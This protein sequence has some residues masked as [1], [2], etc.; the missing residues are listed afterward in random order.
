MKKKTNRR[1]GK[2]GKNLQFHE[3]S[4]FEILVRCNIFE[5]AEL[6]YQYFLRYCQ[7]SGSKKKNTKHVKECD[8]LFEYIYIHFRLISELKKKNI[9]IHTKINLVNFHDFMECMIS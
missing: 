4:G 7:H 6:I 5:Q 2:I 1:F 8:C 3:K 9:F